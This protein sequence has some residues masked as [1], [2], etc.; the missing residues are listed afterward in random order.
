MA[1]RGTQS[2]FTLWLFHIASSYICMEKIIHKWAL[3]P[4]YL[5]QMVYVVPCGTLEARIAI[6][7][8]SEMVP[9]NPLRNLLGMGIIPGKAQLPPGPP[10]TIFVP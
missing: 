2:R 1:S 8:C 4:F 9:R 10:P 7:P 6:V 3:V 5:Y